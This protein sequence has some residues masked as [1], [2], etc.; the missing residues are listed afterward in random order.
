LNYAGT[1]IGC[2]IEWILTELGAAR[3]KIAAKE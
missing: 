2:P 3:D 1:I